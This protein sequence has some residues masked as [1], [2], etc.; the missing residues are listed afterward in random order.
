MVIRR[1]T[2]EEWFVRHQLLLL[3]RSRFFNP[4]LLEADLSRL[5]A[6]F[7]GLEQ[8]PLTAA[9]VKAAAMLRERF[10]ASHRAC[11]ATPWGPRMIEFEEARVNVPVL[12]DI[13]G[14]KVLSAAIVRRADT[15]SLTEIESELSEAKRFDPRRSPVAA[16]LARKGNYIWN[17]LALRMLA[18]AA[19]RIPS[20]YAH[21][22]GGI[23]V[24]TIFSKAA[25]G[26]ALAP[27][28]YG[29]TALS[30][31]AISTFT[32][33]GRPTVRFGCGYDHGAIAGFE[34]AAAGTAFLAILSGKDEEGF[35]QLLEGINR[36]D[37]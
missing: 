31:A 4:V 7:G 37:P 23:S 34:A 15:K 5:A 22:G 21:R 13:D 2:L 28:P 16:F 12:L 14:R 9:C 36:S 6:V 3:G 25:R 1:L 17:R 32:S 19:Y 11:F 30:F 29:P 35:R 10:P 26:L 33:E 27:V 24:S 20:F 8:V 18:W